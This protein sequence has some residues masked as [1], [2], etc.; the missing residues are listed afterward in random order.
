MNEASNRGLKFSY[1]WPPKGKT[2]KII[3]KN[4]PGGCTLISSIFS[5][6]NFLCMIFEDKVKTKVFIKFLQNLKTRTKTTMLTTSE[7]TWITLDNA[8]VHSFHESLNAIKSLDVNTHFL[9][10][11]SPELVP[12][13]LWLN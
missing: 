3:N 8:Q 6:G 4:A 1:R 9:P 13:E 2:D 12:S 7:D 11:L 10:P 5:D